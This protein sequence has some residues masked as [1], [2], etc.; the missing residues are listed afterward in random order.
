ML[1]GGFWTIQKI[2]LESTLLTVLYSVV[3]SKSVF[4]VIDCKNKILLCIK[5]PKLELKTS[6]D[7]SKN[8]CITNPDFLFTNMSFVY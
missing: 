1:M 3:Y 4:A 2:T 8:K 5:N 6:A 7:L